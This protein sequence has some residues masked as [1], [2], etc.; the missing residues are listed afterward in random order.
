M[1]KPLSA[2]KTRIIFGVIVL[3]L[4]VFYFS[5]YK[6]YSLYN[7]AIN[8]D[9]LYTISSYKESYPE[10]KYINEVNEH[11]EARAFALMI[12]DSSETAIENY[13]LF[14][15][16]GKH[17]ENADAIEFMVSGNVDKVRA[18]MKKY[19]KSEFIKDANAKIK[20][21][22]ENEIGFFDANVKSRKLNPEA[23]S[24]KFFRNL[25]LHMKDKNL[26]SFVI[27]FN[28]TNELKEFEDY[29]ASIQSTVSTVYGGG[30]ELGVFIPHPDATNIDPFEGNFTDENI[31]ELEKNVAENL[32]SDIESV[33]GE[34]F[35]E[36]QII[37]SDES[38]NR[39]KNAIFSEA[40]LINIDYKIKNAEEMK[41]P[42]L[43]QHTRSE[44]S[45]ILDR[46]FISYVMDISTYFKLKMINPDDASEFIIDKKGKTAQE[47]ESI[48]TVSDAYFRMLSDTF[49]DFI[50]MAS[51]KL[52]L[53]EDK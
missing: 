6:E 24:V 25:L 5:F 13:K 39:D 7:T 53:T 27:K 3:A 1:K 49:N 36:F 35:F 41:I 12:L 50:T 38:K 21:L 46:K 51:E 42:V 17:F 18:F 52:G 31:D 11:L 14:C 2:Q 22:W 16:G 9:D 34:N 45:N 40:M 23:K 33:F 10:G 8:S 15:S 32:K 44:T 20:E 30:Y 28:Y 29:S 4:L 19:P 43:L 26:T 37:Q 47:Y 48:N